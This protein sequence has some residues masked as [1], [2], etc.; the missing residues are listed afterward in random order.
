MKDLVHEKTSMSSFISSNASVLLAMLSGFL[1]FVCLV[2]YMSMFNLVMLIG[3]ISTVCYLIGVLSYQNGRDAGI[4][5]TM[6]TLIEQNLLV[7]EALDDD[8]TLRV[9]PDVVYYD[10]CNKCSDGVVYNPSATKAHR[11]LVENVEI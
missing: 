10:R 6:E 1:F 4:H 5:Y 11:G 8:V 7:A 9:E 3:S 2:H